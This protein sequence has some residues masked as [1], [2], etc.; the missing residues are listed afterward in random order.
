M[1]N[2]RIHSLI[3]LLLHP[4]EMTSPAVT[5]HQESR[6]DGGSAAVDTVSIQTV[7]D[8]LNAGTKSADELS[9]LHF[10]YALEP[11]SDAE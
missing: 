1:L 10:L 3:P 4:S 5:R 9:S 8:E 11:D 7:G 6:D 2:R